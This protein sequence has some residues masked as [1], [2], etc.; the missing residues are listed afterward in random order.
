MTETG[1]MIDFNPVF[2]S[3]AGAEDYG[4]SL[5]CNII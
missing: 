2:L 4:D 5:K 3:S 1:A